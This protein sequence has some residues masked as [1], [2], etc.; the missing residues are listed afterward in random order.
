MPIEIDILHSLRV[1]YKVLHEWAEE[2]PAS[3]VFSPIKSD[4]SKNR[5]NSYGG[6]CSHA[7]TAS[8]FN[9]CLAG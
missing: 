7:P 6:C 9:A 2:K 8:R 3:S 1:N 5:S 4:P